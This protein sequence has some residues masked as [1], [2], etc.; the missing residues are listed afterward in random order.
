MPKLLRFC[1]AVLLCLWVLPAAAAHAAAAFLP[2]N[3]VKAGMQGIAK[4]VVN[5]TKI[6]EFGVEVLGIMKNKGPA[7]GDL[8]L[9]RTYGEIIDR[10][11]GIVQGMSGSPVYIDGKLVGAIAYGWPLS[12]HRIGMVTPIEDMIKLWQAPDEKNNRV[13]RQVDISGEFEVLSTPVMAAGFTGPALKVLSDKLKPLNLVPYAVGAVPDD[14][15]FGQIEP[16]SSIG[17]ELI[18]GDISLSALGTVTYVEDGK[19]LAFGHPFLRRGNTGYFMTNAHIFT[20]V[21]GLESGFKVGAT[22]EAIGLINQDRSAGIAGQLAKYPSVVPVRIRVMDEQLGRLGDYAVQVVHDEQL[23]PA[24]AAS[25]VFN[26]VDK[27]MDRSGPGT[28]RVSFEIMARDMPG[29]VIKREN[30]FY[31]PGSIGEFTIGEFF[32]AMNMLANNKFNP[33]EIMDVKVEVVVSEERRT[34]SIVEAHP[35]TVS[36]QPGDTVDLLVKLKP[37]RGETIIQTV[38]FVVPKDQPAGP[39]M[40]VVR[41]G[42]LIP[43]PQLLLRQQGIDL[44]KSLNKDKS[45]AEL[46]EDFQDGDRNNDIVVEVMD[47]GAGLMT[48]TPAKAEKRKSAV[49]PAEPPANPVT[50]SGPLPQA[51]SAQAVRE[52]ARTHFTTDYI[53]DNDTQVM[54][55]VL[56]PQ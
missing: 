3:E 13:F 22:G 28:A 53:I 9:V 12:D 45:F 41:G 48:D 46:L 23:A 42:G 31:S 24:L 25:A 30:M 47:T 10:T 38:P 2:V 50:P 4:T 15:Q 18:R 36:A 34:A 39:L 5:G 17:V 1:L 19:V 16:G 49:S 7:G 33:V 55:N 26:A 44:S 40:L 21:E 20:A 52:P 37:Y 6:E 11:G 35:V 32:E 51:P 29:E 27:T 43:L 14:V 56:K 54:L 8:V